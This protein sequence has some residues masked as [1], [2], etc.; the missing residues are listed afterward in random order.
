MA[1][2]QISVTQLKYACLDPEWRKRWI[3]GENPPTFYSA[4][5]ETAPV[6]GTFFHKIAENYVGWL[7][8]SPKAEKLT[9]PDILWHEMYERFAEER[10][11]G[12][13]E[14]GKIDPAYHLGEALKAFCGR[15]SELRHRTPGFQSWQDIFLTKEFSVRSVRFDLGDDHIFISGQIDAVRTHPDHGLEVVDYK[16][17]HGSNMKH[18]LLQ[19]SIYARLLSMTKPGLRFHGVLEYYEPELHEVTV[20]EEEIEAVF[21]IVHP[22]LYELVGKEKR[23]SAQE[24]TSQ[25]PESENFYERIVRE[26]RASA[27]EK[28]SRQSESEKLCERAGKEKRTSAQEKSSQQSES[29]IGPAYDGLS[30]KIQ[31]CYADFKLKVEIIDQHEAPQLIRYKAKPA[32]GV[33][34]VSLANRAEDLQVSLSLTQPPLIAPAQGCVTID[35]PKEKP[36]MVFWRDIVKNP[37]YLRDKSPVSFPVGIGV[38]NQVIAADFAD[39]NMCHALVA[40]ASGSGKSEFLKC[41]VASLITKKPAVN[42]ETFDY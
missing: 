9:A 8:S 41:L 33:K 39:P 24:K 37:A 16:L 26:K 34:V 18:D 38:D 5:Q 13:M 40:G 23:T 10:L 4:P 22:I 25:H 12:L 14:S 21:E 7:T 32:P 2:K 27:Q 19:V 42:L 20:T 3:R 31:K 11:T 15:V 17:S 29:N 36:D 28:S 6:Y 30:H 35:I 1:I